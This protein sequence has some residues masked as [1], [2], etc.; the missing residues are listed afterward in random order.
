MSQFRKKG[1]D[2]NIFLNSKEC[3]QAFETIRKCLCEGAVL[4]HPDFQAASHPEESG[5]P[6]EIFIDASDYG[7][8]GVLCQRLVPH[9]TPKIIAIVCHPLNATQQGWSAMERELYA[10]HGSVTELDRYTKGFLVYAY[11]DHKTNLFLDALLDNRRRSKKMAGWALELQQYNVVRVWLRGESN[12]LGDAPSRAPWEAQLCNQLP[13]PDMPIRELIQKMYRSP[14]E[15]DGSVKLRAEEMQI[16]VRGEFMKISRTVVEDV[17]QVSVT[18]GA[19]MLSEPT[20]RQPQDQ[21]P[22]PKDDMSSG[23][24]TPVFGVEEPMDQEDLVCSLGPGRGGIED[25]MCYPCFGLWIPDASDVEK[26]L[27]CTNTSMVRPLNPQMV[28][29]SVQHVHDRRGENFVVRWGKEVMFE[30]GT[31][32]HTIWINCKTSGHLEAE[33]TAWTYFYSR[34]TDAGN[35]V[36][37]FRGDSDGYGPLGDDGFHGD[38]SRHHTFWVYPGYK[39]LSTLGVASWNPMFETFIEAP[40]FCSNHAFVR[41]RPLG[42]QEFICRGH[43]NNTVGHKRN[44]TKGPERPILRDEGVEASDPAVEDVAEPVVPD[45][46]EVVAPVEAD[47]AEAD[48][49]SEQGR[50]EV[51]VGGDIADL[52]PHCFERLLIAGKYGEDMDFAP[53]YKCLCL[54]EQCLS[55]AKVREGVQSFISSNKLKV[56][57]D[58]VVRSA[59][60]NFELHHGIM[61]RRVYCP[62]DCELQTRIVLPEASVVADLHIPGVGQ[63][64]LSLRLAAILQAHDSEVFGGHVGRNATIERLER[65]YWWPGL[66]DDVRQHC[67]KC[68]RCRERKGEIGYSSWSRTELA[69]RPFRVIQID[70]VGRIR[71]DGDVT[72]ARFV[73]TVVC[74]FSRYCWLIPLVDNDSASVAKSLI[75]KVFCDLGVFPTVIRSDRGPEFTGHVIEYL[76]KAFGIKHVYGSAYHPQS[77]RIVE[78]CHRNMSDL[79]AILCKHD[80]Q[81]WESLL[82]KVQFGLRSLPRK[83]LGDRS[84]IETVTGLRPVFP[85]SI[86]LGVLPESLTADEYTKRLIESMIEVRSEIHKTQLSAIEEGE[87]KAS[88]GIGG[89]FSVG[90]CV[91]VRKP[92]PV[93]NVRKRVAESGAEELVDPEP[94]QEV[95]GRKQH[96]SR[97]LLP[98]TYPRVY[99]VSV[100]VSPVTYKLEDAVSPDIQTPFANVVHVKRLVRLCD[101]WLSNP[102]VDGK[103]TSLEVLGP[104]GVSWRKCTAVEMCMDGRV[105]VRWNDKPEEVSFIDLTRFK[106]RFI[107]PSA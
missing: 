78:R 67:K 23:A 62:I 98:R 5:R 66:P 72:G 50:S 64:S 71:P 86:A 46:P 69:D 33:K 77:Q 68:Q 4:H 85:N 31:T 17:A 90:D 101:S 25:A 95:D 11:I 63:K 40:T 27:P 20:A 100:A 92:N 19:D 36:G 2:F 12:I 56:K 80:P 84:P 16:N 105:G 47:Q 44:R 59:S 57:V 107:V 65:T 94:I 93:V 8:A 83:A 35:S 28:P 106:Y 82:P 58:S 103:T 91:L 21:D 7:W 88:R 49:V 89:G 45:A 18:T 15:L 99:K 42:V 104:D 1:A 48:R 52:P 32:R 73:L 60:D 29:R 79:L 13:I 14:E 81:S 87:E 10:L 43:E 26:L 102:F 6:F 74:L 38:P 9:G 96:V 51:H 24:R 70:C 76:D 55:A 54:Q 41:T 34:F 22:G 61:Y 3:L 30:D 75:D 39:S 37:R 97:R 53:L